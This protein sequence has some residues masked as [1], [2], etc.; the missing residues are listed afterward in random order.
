L[1][2]HGGQQGLG[3]IAGL[4]DSRNADTGHVDTPVG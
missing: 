4:F 2:L 3:S 1:L